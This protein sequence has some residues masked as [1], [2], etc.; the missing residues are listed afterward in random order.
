MIAWNPDF[1]CA[2]DHMGLP[3]SRSEAQALAELLQRHLQNTPEA[4]A[5]A[6]VALGHTLYPEMAGNI[7]YDAEAMS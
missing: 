3:L 5:V 6:K 1:K 7:V 2:V 4:L